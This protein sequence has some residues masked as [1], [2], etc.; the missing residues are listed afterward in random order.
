MLTHKYLSKL[1]SKEITSLDDANDHLEE[2]QDLRTIVAKLINDT[3]IYNLTKKFDTPKLDIKTN[4]NV[5]T[6][7]FPG[8]ICIL[9]TEYTDQFR[10]VY[11]RKFNYNSILGII[12]LDT[13]YV[14]NLLFPLLRI[15]NF[16]TSELLY[17]MN[18]YDCDP[19]HSKNSNLAFN[20]DYIFIVHGNNSILFFRKTGKISYVNF[21]RNNE[22][23][24]QILIEN[25]IIYNICTESDKDNIIFRYETYNIHYETRGRHIIDTVSN[26][27]TGHKIIVSIRNHILYIGYLVTTGYLI[28]SEGRAMGYLISGEGRAKGYYMTNIHL[29]EYCLKKNKIQKKNTIELND[30]KKLVN[31]IID[32]NNFW[33]LINKEGN[34]LFIKGIKNTQLSKG[35]FEK[36]IIDEHVIYK[37]N[38]LDNEINYYPINQTSDFNFNNKSIYHCDSHVT[39]SF[40]FFNSY[41]NQIINLKYELY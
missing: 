40:T 6:D 37:I 7:Y 14:I 4:N 1:C 32:C 38:L 12:Y 28:S 35:L 15:Y 18:I 8:S 2:L 30:K 26:K 24:G 39:S 41:K 23:I 27:N 9:I 31:N 19:Y 20:D 10:L 25:N 16:H 29:I 34:T 17:K 11:D 3:K 33:Y 36:E 21:L 13:D 22:L 5:L